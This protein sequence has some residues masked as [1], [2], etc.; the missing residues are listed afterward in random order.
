MALGTLGVFA[1]P[2]PAVVIAASVGWN[3]DLERVDR[4][5]LLVDA[6]GSAGAFQWEREIRNGQLFAKF[7]VVVR[8]Q[9]DFAFVSF[10]D[11]VAGRRIL[12]GISRFG[13]NRASG[14]VVF[15]VGV[16]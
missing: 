15:A 14:L 10:S 5:L 7:K 13:G 2:S 4:S 12:A 16:G 8:W 3:F 6:L 1:V 9:L 11:R